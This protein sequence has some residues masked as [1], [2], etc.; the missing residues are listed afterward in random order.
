MT[1]RTETINLIYRLHI[2]KISTQSTDYTYRKYQPNLPTTRT[3][4]MSTCT[5]I[6]HRLIW[7]SDPCTLPTY[8]PITVSNQQVYTSITESINKSQKWHKYT[9][10]HT[11]TNTNT[12]THTHTHTHTRVQCLRSASLSHW[13]TQNVLQCLYVAAEL[14]VV[15][16]QH[17]KQ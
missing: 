5:N 10:K 13:N 7:K 6:M 12:H 1:T 8:I 11:H 2:P 9:H 17:T 16:S 3:E 14:H 15:T 4:S